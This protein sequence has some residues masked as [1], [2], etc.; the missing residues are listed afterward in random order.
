MDLIIFAI[1]ASIVLLGLSAQQWGVDSR[2]L[3]VDNRYPAGN[4][5]LF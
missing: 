2:Q 5:G 4:T 3:N 1:F